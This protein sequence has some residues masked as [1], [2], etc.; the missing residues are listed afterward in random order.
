MADTKKV[1]QRI[2]CFIGEDGFSRAEKVGA[3]TARF[4]EKYG[5]AGISFF[6]FSETTDSDRMLQNLKTSFGG[7]SLFATQAL[8]II[9]HPFAKKSATYHE[10]LALLLEHVPQTHFVVFDDDSIDG[11]SV[12]GKA[13]NTLIK[14]GGAT[15]EEFAFP[16][17]P[18]LKKWIERRAQ[19]HEG[20]FEYDA[21]AWL[22]GAATELLNTKEESYLWLLDN[23]IQKLCAHAARKP[24]TLQDIRRVSCLPL[25]AHIFTVMDVLLEK[26][27]REALARTH[28]AAGIRDTQFST[29][30][31]QMVGFL[32][33]QYR[34]FFIV[35][36]MEEDGKKED[37]IASALSWNSRRAW[38]ILKKLKHFSG[39]QLRSYYA[40]TLDCEKKIKTGT[41]DPLLNLDLLIH[42]LTS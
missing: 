15:L 41:G 33:G 40:A 1:S 26:N 13:L 37:E 22:L 21:L 17:G 32:I 3:W 4:D 24:I 27:R 16:T 36:S 10:V 9:R 8:I 35:K 12:L 25:T 2:Y 23:E 38:V 29:N 28:Y 11:K 18:M 39:N 5:R 6:D 14:K 20:S 42:Q 30:L 19:L 31:L 7:N 34:S